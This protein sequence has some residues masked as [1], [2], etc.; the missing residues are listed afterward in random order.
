MAI[1]VFLECRDGEIKNS[2]YEVVAA[3]RRLADAGAG[4]IAGAPAEVIAVLAA[5]APVAA[6]AARAGAYGADRVLHAA[7][8]A[9][10]RG[11]QH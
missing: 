10:A 11:L 4:A 8:E 2:S 3:A 1:L 5:P 6:K 9:F 7:H